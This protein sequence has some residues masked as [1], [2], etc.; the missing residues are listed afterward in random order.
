MRQVFPVSIAVTVFIKFIMPHLS[1]KLFLANLFWHLHR[2]DPRFSL[3]P[4]K[5]DL[6]VCRTEEILQVILAL[7][8]AMALAQYVFN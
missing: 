1:V 6:E 2:K 8:V 7:L 4:S 5:S 3:G